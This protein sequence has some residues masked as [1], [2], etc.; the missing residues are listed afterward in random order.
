[1]EKIGRIRKRLGNIKNVLHLFFRH[2]PLAAVVAE[3]KPPKMIRDVLGDV[4][5]RAANLRQAEI[6]RKKTIPKKG[7]NQDWDP[8]CACEDLET[9]SFPPSWFLCGAPRINCS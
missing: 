3:K 9:P 6:D 8:Y 7:A 5:T 2:R 1:M 4:C